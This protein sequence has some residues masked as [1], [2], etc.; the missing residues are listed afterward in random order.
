MFFNVPLGHA[1][2]P[3]IHLHQHTPTTTSRDGHSRHNSACT[4]IYHRV[5]AH[6]SLSS[7]PRKARGNAR[8][9]TTLY[10]YTVEAG[11]HRTE[12]AHAPTH[13]YYIY[14][15]RP[16][17]L[18]NKTH[19]KPFSSLPLY[20][21]QAHKRAYNFL[22]PHSYTH[23]HVNAHKTLMVFQLFCSRLEDAGGVV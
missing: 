6:I 19:A 7:P 12:Y 22:P 2:A 10:M 17:P 16:P 5:Y 11:A 13:I 8:T 15:S 18:P 14:A 4:S 9:Q 20:L 21:F 23:K 1:R 3:S